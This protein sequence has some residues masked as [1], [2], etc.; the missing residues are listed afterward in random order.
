MEATATRDEEKAARE[1][2]VF[3]A[4]LD[5][6]GLLID[7][8]TVESRP[9]PEPDIYCVHRD[10]GPAVFEL[11]ELRDSDLAKLTSRLTKSGGGVAGLWT[12]DPTPDIFRSKLGKTYQ[13][14]VP[15]DLLV[16]TDG[17]LVTPDDVILPNLERLI[18]A[19]GRGPFRRIF[20]MGEKICREV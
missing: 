4:F 8:A 2:L 13:A 20:L 6:S 5:K 15:V 17:A 9:P 14:G 7:A 11:V 19:H 18:D 12:S 10:D 1:R 3:R 16:Y